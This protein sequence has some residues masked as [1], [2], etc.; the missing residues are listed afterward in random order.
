MRVYENIM[1]NNPSISEGTHSMT[2]LN[3]YSITNLQNNLMVLNTL[4]EI[5]RWEVGKGVASHQMP[6]SSICTQ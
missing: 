6:L 4:Q 5:K 2:S 1:S 3:T